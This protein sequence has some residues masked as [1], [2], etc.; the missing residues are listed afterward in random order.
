MP[1]EARGASL[2]LERVRRGRGGRWLLKV[3]H[4]TKE[5]GSR[6]AGKVTILTKNQRWPKKEN[7]A[8]PSNTSRFKKRGQGKGGRK[9]PRTKTVIRPPWEW[10]SRTGRVK[11]GKRGNA[12]LYH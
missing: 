12:Y 10:D 8:T 5:K 1:C 4:S 2:E 11:G 3:S 7:V 6:R 9:S